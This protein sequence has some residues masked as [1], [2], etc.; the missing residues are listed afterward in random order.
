VLAS[1]IAALDAKLKV[2]LG[3]WAWNLKEI[4]Q[5]SE[6]RVDEAGSHHDNTR[7]LRW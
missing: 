4:A 6:M 3:S 2:C 1:N 5:E 7:S